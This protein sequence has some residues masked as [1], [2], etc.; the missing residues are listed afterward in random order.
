MAGSGALGHFALNAD[1]L[2]AA[3]RFYGAVFGWQFT[4][5]GPAGFFKITTAEGK[6]PGPIGA[7]QQR[8]ALLPDAPTNGVGPLVFFADPSGN[9]VGAMQYG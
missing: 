5:W 8:R 6:L 4:A 2:D 3:R 1:D 9:V 7:L